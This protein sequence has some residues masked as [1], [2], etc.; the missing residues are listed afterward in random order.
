MNILILSP[1]PPFPA[2]GGG[3]LRISNLLAGLAGR[4]EVTCLSFAP[5]T[6]AVAAMAPL[7]KLC[8]L[9]TVI[10]PPPRSLARRAWTTFSSPLPDLALRN[11]AP[12]YSE[13]LS[14]MLAADRYDV[15]HAAS[16]E[17][18]GYG[19]MARGF[20]VPLI[21]LD[22]FNAEYLLQRRAALSDLRRGVG[23]QPRA[24]LA[25][26]YSLAQ[27]RKLAAYEA[28]A[29]HAFDRVLV[30]SE[31]DRAALARLSPRA[32]LRVVPNGVDT[33]RFAP[34]AAPL[35]GPADLLFTATLD[36]RPNIDAV[37][38]FAGEVMPLILAARPDA[39]FVV[40][41]RAAG[42]AVKSL[43]NNA[44][45][46]VVGEVEDVRP[47]VAGAAAYVV[48]MRIG[49]GS[50]LKLLEALALAA[51]VVSTPM[52]A[53]GVAGLRDGEHLLLGD[54]PAAFASAALRLLGDPALGKR[55]GAAGRAHMVARYDWRAIAPLLEAAYGDCRL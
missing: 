40:V 2:R 43:H 16:L 7:R 12:A 44:S 46:V 38:W 33:E 4:H 55:L 48:P 37:R 35:G 19:L 24:L 25:G 17:M 22:Q 5:D 11:V 13:A 1:Y 15:V 51:P 14:R 41:G 49:G 34:G 31:E 8:R 28:R 53:E 9:A 30:V 36:Y 10:G 42:P 3:A 52:G 21:A 27:W 32:D 54:S 45:I 23:G 6:A 50:R 18:A 26:V 47:Y 20:G 29:L 39:R